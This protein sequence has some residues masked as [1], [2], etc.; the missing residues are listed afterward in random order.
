MISGG[1]AGIAVQSEERVAE[2]QEWFFHPYSY[3]GVW[4]KLKPTERE[5]Q[6]YLF[7]VEMPRHTERNV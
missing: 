2:P 5:D 6:R 4:N 7:H 3:A 1:S